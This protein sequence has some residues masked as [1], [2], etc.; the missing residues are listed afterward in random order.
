MIYS[1]LSS[2][3]L[4]SVPTRSLRTGTATAL[5]LLLTSSSAFAVTELVTNGDFATNGGNGQLGFNTSA[6]GWSVNPFPGSYAFLWNAGSGTS[7]TTADTTGAPGVFTS[8]PTNPVKL[9]GPGTGSSNGLTVSPDGGAFIGSSPAFHNGPISQTLTGLTPGLKT[10]VSFDY[11]GAQQFGFSG[12]SGA[13]WAVSLGS[14]TE[15]TAILSTSSHGFSGWKTASFTFTPTS[16]SE[17]LK[18]LSIGQTTDVESFVL[19]DSVSATQG[20]IPEPSTWVMMALGFAGLAYAGFRSNRRKP[21]A[22]A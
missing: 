12:P 6:T 10:I 5:L 1:T 17:V 19:L 14:E 15:D 4:L 3:L 18:F 22:I 20:V 7:G 2:R 11:A 16:T 21:V 9:W 13:G 8:P